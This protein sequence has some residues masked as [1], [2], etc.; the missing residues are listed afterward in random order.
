MLYTLLLG[1][2]ALFT[3]LDALITVVG[4]GFGCVELNPVVT[5]WGVEFWAIFRILLLACMLTT[6]FAGYRL[7]FKHFQKGIG[8][9]KATLFVLDFYIGAVV[10]FGFIAIFTKLLI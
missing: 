4:T 8:M 1:A 6:F 7:C 5:M 2:L 10:F 9:L 3:L